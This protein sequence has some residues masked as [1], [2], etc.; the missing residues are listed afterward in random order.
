MPAWLILGLLA[1]G[2][3]VLSGG[4]RSS[5][6]AKGT[7]S[8]QGG[9]EEGYNVGRKGNPAE[10]SSVVLASLAAS[11]YASPDE[12]ARGYAAGHEAG[13]KARLAALDRAYDLGYQNG[14]SSARARTPL[15][16]AE[17]I[18]QSDSA[19]STESAAR[20]VE[21]FIKGYEEGKKAPASEAP[22]GGFE[23]VDLIGQLA[24]NAGEF[25]TAIEKSVGLGNVQASANVQAVMNKHTAAMRILLNNQQGAFDP[26]Q[27]SSSGTPR[28]SVAAWLLLATQVQAEPASV[29]NPVKVIATEAMIKKYLETYAP[30][31]TEPVWNEI[32]SEITSLDNNGCPFPLWNGQL[33]LRAYLYGQDVSSCTPAGLCAMSSALAAPSSFRPDFGAHE[34]IRKGECPTTGYYAKLDWYATGDKSVSESFVR[35]NALEALRLVKNYAVYNP[36]CSVAYATQALFSFNW[37][38]FAPRS[39]NELDTFSKNVVASTKNEDIAK[40]MRAFY[41][42]LVAGVAT[43]I[44]MN[45]NVP[46]SQWR[47]LVVAAWDGWN[48]GISLRKVSTPAMKDSDYGVVG[49]AFAH[50]YAL[51]R[52][53]AILT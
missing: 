19:R 41:E 36:F 47:D 3:L 17:E 18:A 22:P 15:K 26:T 28:T 42:S 5:D 50:K 35:D 12:Y 7:E 27:P 49:L 20:Y 37:M 48:E 46:A 16:T 6:A 2:A 29:G 11:R 43:S 21:G 34:A 8:F 4:D 53:N 9:Y 23:P 13:S 38:V 14:L 39:C 10:A 33:T 40:Q 45:L 32:K 30:V 44:G 25:W 52:A 31:F 1:A 51:D 24:S